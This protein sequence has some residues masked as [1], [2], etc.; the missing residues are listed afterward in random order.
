MLFFFWQSQRV[1]G[2]DIF[3]D[4][5]ENE[6]IMFSKTTCPF[7]SQARLKCCY[8]VVL[9]NLRD[10]EILQYS[11]TCQ[12]NDSAFCLSL[13]LLSAMKTLPE[14]NTALENGWL[15]DDP[16]RLGPGLFSEAFAVSFGEGTFSVFF[17]RP[18]MSWSPLGA[19]LWLL[20]WMSFQQ[21]PDRGLIHLPCLPEL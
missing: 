9:T 21:R 18:R 17:L 6:V 11:A 5:Q 13:L 14:T 7:C 4:P 16:F 15:E 3:C 12:L 20:S 19:N 8:I 10:V 2:L 1:G